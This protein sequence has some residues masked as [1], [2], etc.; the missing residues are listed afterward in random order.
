M[1]YSNVNS[2][3]NVAGTITFSGVLSGAGNNLTNVQTSGGSFTQ[4]L[5]NL[6]VSNSVTTTNILTYTVNSPSVSD[7][8]TITVGPYAWTY[9]VDGTINLPA[10]TTG[11]SILQT[12]SSAISLITGDPPS[13]YIFDSSGLATFPGNIF[14]SNSL[15]TT[16]V[17][18]TGNVHTPI[19]KSD[20][21]LFLNSGNYLWACGSDGH[22]N[23]PGG[24]DGQFSYVQTGANAIVLSI[25]GTYFTTFA[26]TGF[27]YFPDLIYADGGVLSNIQALSLHNKFSN[28]VIDNYGNIYLTYDSTGLYAATSNQIIDNMGSLYLNSSSLGLIDKNG[29]I[30]INNKSYINCFSANVT[31]VVSVNCILP[32]TGYNSVA[33]FGTNF[34]T[35]GVSKHDPPQYAYFNGTSWGLS[36]S[37]PL[38]GVTKIAYG[39]SNLVAIS[40]SGA[41]YSIDGGINWVDPGN[42]GVATWNSIAFGGGYFVAVSRDSHYSYSSD[43]VNWTEPGSFAPDDSLVGIAYGAGLFVTIG[44]NVGVGGGGI[45]YYTNDIT[46]GWSSG[47]IADGQWFAVVYGSPYFVAIDIQF[48]QIAYNDDLASSWNLTSYGGTINGNFLDIS[49]GNGVFVIISD[50]GTFIYSANGIDWFLTDFVAPSGTAWSS[51]AYGNGQ[52]IAVGHQAEYSVS[53]NGI[54]WLTTYKTIGPSID[55]SNGLIITPKISVQ[56]KQ[57][58]YTGAVP[59]PQIIYSSQISDNNN[60]LPPPVFGET[61]TGPYAMTVL[62]R[63]TNDQ[64]NAIEQPGDPLPLFHLELVSNNIFSGTQS[65]VGFGFKPYSLN[66]SPIFIIAPHS[67]NGFDDA[68]QDFGPP[69]NIA[70]QISTSGNGYVGIGQFATPTWPFSVV[71][72]SVATGQGIAAF[73]TNQVIQFFDENTDTSTGPFLL[74]ES[75]YGIGIGTSLG[76]ILFNQGSSEYMRVDAGGNVGIRTQSPAYTLDVNGSLR[77]SGSASLANLVVSNSVTTTNIVGTLANVGTLNVTTLETVSNLRVYLANVTSVAN[78]TSLNVKNLIVSIAN[79]STLNVSSFTVSQP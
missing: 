31:S 10:S 57:A 42:L 19:V 40:Q 33:G 18:I 27:T 16:N 74:G 52:F 29:N 56:S 20:G 73:G 54:N 6:V 4:P 39:I 51:L 30:I 79:V 15:T 34:V 58:T 47:T 24:D 37:S 5:A 12:P 75:G 60:P 55:I 64:H 22:F 7:P 77:S 67:R 71:P 26:N 46:S 36:V 62:T 41:A 1:G 78:I 11:A 32:Y 63:D 8:L 28:T 43:N 23:L 45:V 50:G 69:D 70:I 49:Y 25:Q 72:F 48:N 65:G 44:Y 21:D 35:C 61:T 38:N 76:P 3:L 9:G 66:S 68:N 2:D 13:T 17:F 59:G 53:F 14:A